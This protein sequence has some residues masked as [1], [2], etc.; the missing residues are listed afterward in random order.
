MQILGTLHK[1]AHCFLQERFN[2]SLLATLQKTVVQINVVGRNK[3]HNLPK[4]SL[5]S[6]N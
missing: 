5:Q 6:T 1:V 2:R 4:T 3:S